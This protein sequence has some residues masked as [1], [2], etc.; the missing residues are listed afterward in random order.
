MRWP[1]LGLCFLRAGLQGM[2]RLLEE[3]VLE[4][5]AFL[6]CL[7]GARGLYDSVNPGLH[8]ELAELSRGQRTIP[9]IVVGKTRVPPDSG[10]DV[11]RQ[12]LPSEISAGLATGAILMHQ[13]GMRDQ[14]RRS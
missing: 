2:G 12:L 5:E 3:L 9:G 8:S 11:I 13:F 7:D 1:G 14:H 4:L 6:V 10:I